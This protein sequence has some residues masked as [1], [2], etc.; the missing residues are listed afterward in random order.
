LTGSK[1]FSGFRG[2]DSLGGND[3]AES[4]GDLEEGREE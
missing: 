1:R 3:E 4:T 2:N